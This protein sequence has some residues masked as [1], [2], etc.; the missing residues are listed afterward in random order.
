MG[1]AAILG[2]S[3]EALTSIASVPISDSFAKQALK[4]VIDHAFRVVHTPHDLEARGTIAVASQLAGTAASHSGGSIAHA[5]SI[6]ISQLTEIPYGLAMRILLPHTLRYEESE[7]RP[8]L[9]SLEHILKG[10][11]IAEISSEQG[12]EENTQPAIL[13]V[14]EFLQGL[15]S[16]MTPPMARRFCDV[17]DMKGQSRMLPVHRIEA[18]AIATAGS[19]D[20]LTSR[21]KPPVRDLVRI[22]EASYWGYQLDTK[23][24]W[25]SRFTRKG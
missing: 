19:Y 3:L 20:M 1:V 2:R 5:L 24:P 21:S 18:M 6:T 13:W 16:G 25:T 7:T 12:I 9:K 10:I 17:Y 22:L 8:I 23:D 11:T 15:T 14:S 4:L